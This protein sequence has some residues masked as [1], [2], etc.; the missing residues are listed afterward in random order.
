MLELTVLLV[1]S[2]A[3]ALSFV[4]SCVGLGTP[5]T[6]YLSLVKRGTEIGDTEKKIFKKID[7][8]D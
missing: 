5:P 7:L 6:E 2:F 8:N 3:T 4:N 1:V